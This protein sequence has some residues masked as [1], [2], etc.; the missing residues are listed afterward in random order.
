MRGEKGMNP[1]HEG[2]GGVLGKR[3]KAVEAQ[4]SEKKAKENLGPVLGERK[5]Q[6]E[7]EV[8]EDAEW[9]ARM[10]EAREEIKSQGDKN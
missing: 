3:L 6:V 9:E 5:K 2:L 1:G 10:K 8:W 7:E 4:I